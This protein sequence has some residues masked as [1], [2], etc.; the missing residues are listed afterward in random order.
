MTCTNCAAEWGCASGSGERTATCPSLGTPWRKSSSGDAL[1]PP[2]G[3]NYD[4]GGAGVG[5]EG[6]SEG[7]G[8]RRS[9]PARRSSCPTVLLASPSTPQA[10]HR[11]S[12]DLSPG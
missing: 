2:P 1:R 12:P 9:L 3:Q 8:C 6:T 5:W 7:C 11:L 4:D 10:D